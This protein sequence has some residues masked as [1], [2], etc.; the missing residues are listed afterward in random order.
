[1]ANPTRLQAFG[2]DSARHILAFF[3]GSFGVNT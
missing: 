3:S 1:M 2:E